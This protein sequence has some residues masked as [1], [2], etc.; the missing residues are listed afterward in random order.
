MSSMREDDQQ[1][2]I[3]NAIRHAEAFARED[4]ALFVKVLREKFFAERSPKTRGTRTATR[5]LT[6]RADPGLQIYQ[7]PRFIRNARE[8]ARRTEKRMRIIGGTTV[9][10]AE[11]P[12]CVAVGSDDQ[13]FCSG[14]LIG[15]NTVLTACHCDC[16]RPT[17]VYFGNNVDERGEIVNV[18]KRVPHPDYLKGKNNDLMVLVL[19]SDVRTVAPRAI[20]PGALIDAAT[21]ARVVGFGNTEPSGFFGYGI[22]RQTDVPI[23]SSCCKGSVNGKDDQTVYGCDPDFELIAGKPLLVKDTCNGDSGGPLYLSDGIGKWFLAGATS[24][25]TKAAINNCGDGGVY[26]RVDRYLDWIKDIPGVSL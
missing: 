20:A 1:K 9:K 16:S 13:W 18:S 26:V 15:K 3:L 8:L 23:A 6:P 5:T 14:T 7:D 19:E 22:K 25:A 4:D 17:R 2:L 12:D 10:G 11:F 24:R 21:D